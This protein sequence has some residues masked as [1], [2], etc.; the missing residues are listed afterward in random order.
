MNLERYLRSIRAPFDNVVLGTPRL[1]HAAPASANASV[2]RD[3]LAWCHV[4][5]GPGGAPSP[6]ERPNVQSRMAVASLVGPD[7]AL[8]M[9]CANHLACDIDGSLRLQALAGSVPRLAWRAQV[10][11]NDA[12]W[13]RLRLPSD[14]W[15]AGWASTSP[16]GLRRW[17]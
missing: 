11:L 16:P 13:W 2:Y 14:P 1:G 17:P 15:D 4:G 12:C 7:H 9:A 5:A 6:G 8:A 10:K 3:L